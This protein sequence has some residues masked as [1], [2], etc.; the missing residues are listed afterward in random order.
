MES[1][2]SGMGRPARSSIPLREALE[3]DLPHLAPIDEER[4]EAYPSRRAVEA[5]PELAAEC[6]RLDAGEDVLVHEAGALARS[7]KDAEVGRHR[8]RAQ[9]MEERTSEQ[10]DD[11]GH[12]GQPR[13]RGDTAPHAARPA[14]LARNRQPTPSNRRPAASAA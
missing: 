2:P 14:S 3:I 11:R 12:H 7:G 1:G 10:T 6:V 4:L 9:R 13:D 5:Q 8:V